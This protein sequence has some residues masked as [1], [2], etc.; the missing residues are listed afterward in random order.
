MS[1]QS[2]MTLIKWR[3]A[4]M[5]NPKYSNPILTNS[6]VE[7]GCVPLNR[8]EKITVEVMNKDV[9]EGIK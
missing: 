3:A 8:V 5:K 2:N 7:S 1:N 9:E 4:G 6:V